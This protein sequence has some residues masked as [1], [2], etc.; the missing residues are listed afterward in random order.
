MKIL[1]KFQ[2]GQLDTVVMYRKIASQIKNPEAAPRLKE[3]AAEEGNRA[4]ILFKLT[5]KS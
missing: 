1:L 5:E 4:A 2:Q 3:I